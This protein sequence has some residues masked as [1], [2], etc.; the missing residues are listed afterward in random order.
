[1]K[2]ALALAS[3]CLL[4]GCAV[5]ASKEAVVGCQAADAGTT[6]HAA[7]LGAR[8]AN[9]FVEWLLAQFGPSGFIAA[10]IGVT[11]LVLHYHPVLP[12]GLVSLANGAV[13]T[14]GLA[15]KTPHYAGGRL[16]YADGTGA[17]F[18]APFDAR[19]RRLTGPGEPLIERVAMNVGFA[20]IG[21]AASAVAYFTGNPVAASQLLEV[22]R[23]GREHVL[24]LRPAAYSQ[25]RYSPDGRWVAVGIV[26]SGLG[27]GDIWV[28]D[29]PSQRL[30]RVTLD[31]LN[32]APEWTPDGRR[33]L[34]SRFTG[35]IFELYQAAAD[36]STGSEPFFS[37]RPNATSEA[38]QLPDGRL[39]FREDVSGSGGD[40]R[41]APVDSPAA[42][43]PL[44]ATPFQERAPAPS[45]DGRWLAFTSNVSG[46][47]AVY[48]RRLDE[49][50]ARWRV[51]PGNGTEPRWGPGGR[52]IFYR[53]G[54]TVMSVD[55]RLGDE[56]VFGQPRRLFVGQYQASGSQPLYDVA[57]D[58]RRFLMVRDLTNAG[59]G[60]SLH[61]IIH[62]FAAPDG[63][64]RSNP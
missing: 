19:R 25:P 58:G 40:I 46:A 60:L 50:A 16:V 42:A 41:V 44:A 45:P 47:L 53:S 36:G 63:S 2:A 64:G 21:V 10:K 20:R 31:T 43:Q 9:P 12:S 54:D 39:V 28:Y 33:L 3:S 5:L 13:E 22:D 30:S 4:G 17:V 51:S 1:M 11:L 32:A 48:L 24:P 15:G 59:Q 14:V 62:P 56:P 34:F 18:A 37:R 6:L 35:G 27:F 8:E 61:I 52:E 38:H 57:P 55:V 29:I 49:S 7:G 23:S 26:G